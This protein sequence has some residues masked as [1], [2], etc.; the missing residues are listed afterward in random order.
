VPAGTVAPVTAPA[1]SRCSTN[2]AGN[3]S[4]STSR[5]GGEA[6][7]NCWLAAGYELSPDNRRRSV[8]ADERI[9]KTEVVRDGQQVQRI[10]AALRDEGWADH[11][12]LARELRAWARLSEE[13]N[14]YRATV[15][16]YTNDLCSRDYLAEFAS[17]ASSDLRTTIEHHVAPADEKFH[18]STVEDADGRLGRYFRIQREDGWWWHRQPASGPLADYLAEDG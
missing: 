2:T 9:R 15:D 7:G 14:T 6:S 3:L 17:R 13:V 18:E 5:P 1:A 8:I 10:E 4:A 16:D 11:V 12:G